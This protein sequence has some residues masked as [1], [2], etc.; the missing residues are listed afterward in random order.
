MTEYFATAPAHDFFWWVAGSGLVAA[1]AFAGSFVQLHRARLMENMPTARLRSAAQGYVELEGNA[2]VMDGPPIIAPLTRT[3]CVWWRFRIEKKV[4]SGKNTKWVTVSSGTSDDCFELDDGTGRCVVDPEGAKVIP[5][6]RHRWYG[7]SERPDVPP[8][9]GTGFLRAGFSRYRYT[10]ERLHDAEPVY[11]LGA[12]R[13]QTGAPDAFDEQLDLRDLLAKWKSDKKMMALF[14][15]NKDGNVDQKEWEAARRVALK[16]VRDE[17][18]QRAVETPDLNILARPRDGRPYIL[19]G[20]PQAKLIRR[21][22]IEA[23]GALAVAA[24]AA[25][26]LLKALLARGLIA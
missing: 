22:R 15:A 7:S 6:H 4:Q 24:I 10:E 17:H 23:A 13:T 25:F 19:S 3:R 11:A 1:A 18:V 20:V 21:F 2:R 5:A 26:V 12:F 8:H 16:K 9:L 14:D